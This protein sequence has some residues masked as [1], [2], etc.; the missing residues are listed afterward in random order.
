[1]R[2]KT[3]AYARHADSKCPGQGSILTLNTI[4]KQI[5][6][7]RKGHIQKNLPDL[8]EASAQCLLCTTR[9]NPFE[10]KKGV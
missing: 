5:R 1:M 7:P 9:Q 3:A 6:T 4:V 8:Q 10:E 2:L